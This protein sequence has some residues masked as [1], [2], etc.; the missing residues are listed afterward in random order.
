MRGLGLR[1]DGLSSTLCVHFIFTSV[2]SCYFLG[3]CLLC[4]RLWSFHPLGFLPFPLLPLLFLCLLP[5]PV[6]SLLP[7]LYLN[8]SMFQLK[9]CRRVCGDIYPPHI[10]S[11]LFKTYL[12]N[13]I[14]AVLVKM[15][16]IMSTHIDKP[17]KFFQH[18]LTG[19]VNI[20]PNLRKIHSY[21]QNNLIGQGKVTWALEY[22]MQI[23]LHYANWKFFLI[24]K[25]IEPLARLCYFQI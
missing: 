13:L 6:F 8:S 17:G 5:L 4:V 19:S 16:D 12:T 25:K 20:F 2:S 7:P 22:I 21:W 3:N 10:L 1:N 15:L 24:V 9:L 11:W 18:T 23:K 14:K